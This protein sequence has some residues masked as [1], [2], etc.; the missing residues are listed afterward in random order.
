MLIYLLLFYNTQR[1]QKRIGTYDKQPWEQ[2]VEHRILGG[3]VNIPSKNVTARTEYIDVDLVRGLFI[4]ICLYLFYY[5]LV[6]YLS[7]SSK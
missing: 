2:T 3:F 6:I 1:Y 5:C 7:E 4:L